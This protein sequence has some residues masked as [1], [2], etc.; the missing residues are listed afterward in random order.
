MINSETN[1][2]GYKKDIQIEQRFSRTIKA[3]L[4]NQFIV[5][6]EI[7]DLE[8][9]T[10]FLLLKMEPFRIGVRL[11]R[12]EYFEAYNQEFT[13]RWKRPSGVDTEIQKIRKGLVDYI[14][15]GFIDKKEKNIIQYF[16]GDLAVFVK[17]Q[18]QPTIKPNN[19][20]D[21]W[22]AIYNL[23]DFPDEFIKK[24]YSLPPRSPK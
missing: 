3:I 10:D 2:T 22:F 4:G 15:Y 21:S 7:E 19:P 9:G 13:I 11:R 23:N 17:Q 5:Q 14:L 6:D 20:L 12:Y 8:N 1:L 18:I 24:F 16:I